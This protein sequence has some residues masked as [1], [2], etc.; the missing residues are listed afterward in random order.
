MIKNLYLI[1]WFSLA[2][3]VS[4]SALTGTLTQTAVEVYSLLALG[5]VFALMLWSV[6]VNTREIKTE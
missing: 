6:I 2:T 5:L 1:A 4:A 3:I